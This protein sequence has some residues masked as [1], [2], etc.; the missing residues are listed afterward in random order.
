MLSCA[1]I[2]PRLAGLLRPQKILAVFFLQYNLGK[3]P[4]QLGSV[5]FQFKGSF[6]EAGAGVRDVNNRNGSF[7]GLT[8]DPSISC[9]I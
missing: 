1:Y 6:L 8:L 4:L 3:E 5:G 7:L 9:K 2:K